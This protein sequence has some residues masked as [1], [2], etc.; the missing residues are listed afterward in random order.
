MLA[1]TGS[2]SRTGDLIG[3]SQSAVTGQMQKLELVLGRV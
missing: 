1:E 2:F 3:R